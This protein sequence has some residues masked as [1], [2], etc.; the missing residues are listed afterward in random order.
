MIFRAIRGAVL[1]LSWLLFVFFLLGCEGFQEIILLPPPP[2]DEGFY[3]VTETSKNGFET[4]D[5]SLHWIGGRMQSF[6]LCN[7][8]NKRVK[9]R[10]RLMLD[11]EIQLPG[12][13]FVIDGTTYALLEGTGTFTQ[14]GF[15]LKYVY[16][17]GKMRSVE[18]KI[19]GFSK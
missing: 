13:N 12:Q 6:E 10:A 9:I 7:F 16:G 8:E 14:K 3:E 18:R 17:E 2:I 5:L 15:E 11:R 4:Y 1:I 19:V